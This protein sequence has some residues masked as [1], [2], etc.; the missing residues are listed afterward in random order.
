MIVL[1]YF[2]FTLIVFTALFLLHI[3][4][5]KKN[6]VNIPVEFLDDEPVSVE[7]PQKY[8]HPV[9]FIDNNGYY[10]KLLVPVTNNT[11]FDAEIIFNYYTKQANQLPTGISSPL[12]MSTELT[13]IVINSDEI[14]LTTNKKLATSDAGYYPLINSLLELEGI[15]KVKIIEGNVA[16]TFKTKNIFNLFFEYPLVE[17][18]MITLLFYSESNKD[19]EV[20]VNFFISKN[21]NKYERIMNHLLNPPIGLKTHLT[22]YPNIVYLKDQFHATTTDKNILKNEKA[23]NQLKYMLDKNYQIKLNN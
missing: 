14:V 2:K 10:I 12:I 21:D 13:S 8:T 18:E 1:R 22:D 23:F 4:Y 16:K 19:L 9:Y 5:T 17:Q 11:K 7:L 20:E 15:K 6:E 3:Y